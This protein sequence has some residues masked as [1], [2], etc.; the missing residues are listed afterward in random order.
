MRREGLPEFF[1]GHL[2]ELGALLLCRIGSGFGCRVLRFL[3]VVIHGTAPFLDTDGFVVPTVERSPLGFP[4]G[5]ERDGSLDR[6]NPHYME[7]EATYTAARPAVTVT[8]WRASVERPDYVARAIRLYEQEP[9]E[10]LVSA[11][12]GLYVRRWVTARCI[13]APC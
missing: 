5:H 12:L 4:G 2:A 1:L 7:A 9:G 8:A 10:A 3:V 6:L 11:R 13:A